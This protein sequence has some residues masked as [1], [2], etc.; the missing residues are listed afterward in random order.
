MKRILM[1]AAIALTTFAAQAAA[2]TAQDSA[3]AV[4]AADAWLAL[5]DAGKYAESWQQA[6]PLF[7]KQ[8]SAAAWQ[9]ALENVRTPLGKLVKRGLV[10]AKYTT[11]LPGA[12]DG[13]YW[14]IHETTV[15]EH[16]AS[17]VETVIMVPADGGWKL[18][19][20]FIR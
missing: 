14:V 7:Q 13:Q 18:A 2:P 9:A 11:T 4:K 10:D 20:Y 12:P 5:V 8:E 15:F 1:L 17:A 16:K 6:A 3:P 19:G